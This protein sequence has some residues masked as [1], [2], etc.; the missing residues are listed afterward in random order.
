MVGGIWDPCLGEH[1]SQDGDSASKFAAQNEGKGEALDET[2]DR[3]WNQ[4]DPRDWIDLGPV[5]F[6]VIFIRITLNLF[7]VFGLCVRDNF[8]INAQLDAKFVRY[9]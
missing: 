2:F 4:D 7:G 1:G 5:L 3:Y 6:P 9:W 8:I